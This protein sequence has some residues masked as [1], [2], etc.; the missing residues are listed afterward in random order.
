MLKHQNCKG[1]S[2]YIQLKLEDKHISSLKFEYS[3]LAH[4][5]YMICS[6]LPAKIA[7]LYSIA[8]TA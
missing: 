2:R 4:S 7:E 3:S 6:K 8:G 5:K 1:T